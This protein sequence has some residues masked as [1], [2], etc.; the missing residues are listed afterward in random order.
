MNNSKTI[1][2]AGRLLLLAGLFLLTVLLS[3]RHIRRN[4]DETARRYRHAGRAAL[5]RLRT[6]R[7]A[8]HRNEVERFYEEVSKALWGFL[9][10]KLSIP[11]AE[12]SRSTA[13][14]AMRARGTGEETIQAFGRL[15]DTCEMAR[16]APS[17]V[18]HDLKAVYSDA[19]RF[20]S[21]V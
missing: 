15:I 14:E 7:D 10:D 11:V 6:A 2:L 17:A 1:V 20:I 19:A 12:L 9:S 3:R 21:K 8:M 5:K 16:Y 4:A 13:E 18:S